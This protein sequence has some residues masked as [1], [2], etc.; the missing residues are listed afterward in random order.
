[1]MGHVKDVMGAERMAVALVKEE[2]YLAS[3]G[4][5]MMSDRST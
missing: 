3:K 1:M 4:W 2:S 5:M